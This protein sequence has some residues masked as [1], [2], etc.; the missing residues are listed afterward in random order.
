[1]NINHY[2][3]QSLR[4][5]S[6]YEVTILQVHAHSSNTPYSTSLIY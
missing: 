1:M 6:N 4:N 3:W 5:K 2:R